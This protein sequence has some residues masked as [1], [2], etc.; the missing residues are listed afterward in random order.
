MLLHTRLAIALGLVGLLAGASGCASD[1]P[2]K[3]E[4][5]GHKATA[6]LDIGADH[7]KEGRPALALREF[8]A[9]EQLD[10]KNPQIQYALGEAYLAQGKQAESEKHYRRAIEIA[11]DNHDAKLS[12]SA[13]MILEKRY[14]EAEAPCRELVDDPTYPT[15]WRALANLGFAEFKL[16]KLNEAREHL[17]KA[18]EYQQ[19]YLPATLSLAQIDVQE[20]RRV[21]ALAL[22]RSALEV[23][24]GVP[25]VQAE[26]NY[27]IAEI[28][29]SLGKRAEAMSHLSSAV[30][31]APQG[32]W[33]KKSQEYL[34]L[35]R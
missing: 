8:L 6:R 28:Y 7:L 25:N 27:R 24:P 1:P 31:Q 17:E 26:V 12:L 19:D 16:G 33:G 20:G 11:P 10:P 15:P 35:L 18:R 3:G 13:L 34:K 5:N 22:L 9:A 23:Q 32:V 21:D 30:A 14:P 4:D 29:V 2:Q